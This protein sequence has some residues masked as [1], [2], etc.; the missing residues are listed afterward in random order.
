MLL[1]A[2]HRND[3]LVKVSS[4]RAVS[5]FKKFAIARTRSPAP[6][7]RALPGNAHMGRCV[8]LTAEDTYLASWERLD[9]LSAAL[10]LAALAGVNLYLTVFATG[11]AIHFHWITLGRS[12]SRSK[13]SATLGSSASPVFSICSNFSPTRFHGW[14][15]SGTLS[16]L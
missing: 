13:S 5:A 4:S 6:V 15:Q 3:L 14:I 16:T 9:L 2:S 1:S 11:L 12:I 7:T 8:T 10:G